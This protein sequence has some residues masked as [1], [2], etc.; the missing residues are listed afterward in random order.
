MSS[1]S[2]GGS[3]G[4]QLPPEEIGDIFLSEEPLG[5]LLDFYL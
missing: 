4:G 5:G 1:G 3:G 2:E